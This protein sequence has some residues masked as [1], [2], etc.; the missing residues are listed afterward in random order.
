MP[1]QPFVTLNDG[2]VMPQLGLG[3]W[4]TEDEEAPAVIRAALAAGYRL[5]DT[6]AIYGNERGVGRGLRSGGRDEVFVTTKL[7][8]DRQGYDNT[9]RAFDES[10][11]LLELDYVDLYLI[12]WPA[13]RQDLYVDSWRAL[14]T[15]QQSGR[16]RSIG[17]S[18]FNAE[19]IERIAGETGVV[20]A[21]NQIELHPGFQQKALRE[22]HQSH[23]IHT[24]SWSPLG[25]G[26]TLAEPA[27]VEIA[28]KHGRTPAQVVIRWHL[29]LGLIAIPK[30]VRAERI[31]ENFDVF[32]FRLD[33]DDHARI[34]A[35]DSPEGRSGPDP[36]KFP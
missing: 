17:V 1:D 9:L 16:A 7:W 29:D 21:V 30:S 19:Q 32:G 4:K 31:R 3:V 34:A 27:I 24:E 2:H 36:A 6:A 10:L 13:P 11:A 18:N 26:A 5:I 20:P 12:H 8:N 25:R 15:L 22:F 14:V 33:E 28:R 23:G 35:L